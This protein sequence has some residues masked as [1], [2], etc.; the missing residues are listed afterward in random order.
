MA[1][2]RREVQEIREKIARLDSELSERLDARARLSHEIRALSE[3][4][5]V[6]DG[7]ESEWLEKLVAS[8]S[9]D[10]PAESLRAIFREI[11]A[12]GRA[13]EQPARVA[14][15]GPEGGFCHQSALDA[16]GATTQ[17]VETA[18][19]AEALSEVIRSRVAFAMIPFESSSEGFSQP[20]LMALA[21]TDL[22]LVGERFASATYSLMSLAGDKAQIE[23][24]YMTAAAHAACQRFLDAELPRASIIDVRSPRVAAELA[25]EAASSAAVVPER[26]GRAAGLDVLRPNVGDAAEARNRYGIAGLR[27]APRSGHDISCLLF[28]TDNQPGSLYDTLR[29]FAERGINLRKLQSLPARRDGFEYIFYVEISGHAS[30]RA[31]VT[32]I[33]AIKRSVGY[34][35]LLG[36]FPTAG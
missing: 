16:F 24:V 20:S 19:A 23:K 25:K 1:D 18:N 2:R 34:F 11:R 35:R 28:S 32:A 17:T 13:L 27:P 33:E 3:A 5:P 6:A 4:E 8:A 12:A 9:G 22:V 36:S 21:E 7:G 29:H 30:D 31:V 26:A 14:I 10:M 15:V